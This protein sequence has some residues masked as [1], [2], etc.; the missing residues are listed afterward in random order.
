M[1]FAAFEESQEGSRPVELFTFTT[2]ATVNRWTS[3]EDD[4]SVA[5]DTWVA[6]T[7]SRDKLAG[8]GADQRDQSLIVTVPSTNSVAKQ[9][10]NSVPG[11]RTTVVIERVQRTDGP[12]FEVIKIFEG[13][14]SAVGFENQGRT[15]KINVEPLVAAT[16]RPIP[17]F[18]YQ[19]LCNHVLYD[20]LCQVDD[21]DPAF[22]LSAAVVTAVSGNTITVT[23]VAAFGAEFFDAGFVEAFG[24]SD[25]R[26]ILSSSGDVLT[27]TLPFAT[28]PLGSSVIVFACCNHTIAICKSKF[29]IVISFGGFAFIPTKN[30]FQTGITT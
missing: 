11:V 8:G 12:A 19:G 13:R 28:S 6:V 14:I 20:A 1:T 3:A 9:F 26:L 25:R 18:N 23:G 27:L 4:V 10:I 7:I 24:G 22:R 15:A 17:R 16:S 30:I 29:N 5:G 2:G 21:T